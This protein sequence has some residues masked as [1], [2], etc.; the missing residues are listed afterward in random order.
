MQQR[1]VHLHLHT[2]FSIVDGLVQIS[3]LLDALLDGDMCAVA[4]TDV[5]NLF[6]AVKFYQAAVSIGI[7]PILG[8]DLPFS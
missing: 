3:P 7:K 1:F 8:A 6:A 5:C 4:V 2:E